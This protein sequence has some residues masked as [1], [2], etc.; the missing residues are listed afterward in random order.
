MLTNNMAKSRLLTLLFN[1]DKIEIE[2]KRKVESS[3]FKVTFLRTNINLCLLN[4]V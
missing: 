3:D 4:L 1:Y 2:L